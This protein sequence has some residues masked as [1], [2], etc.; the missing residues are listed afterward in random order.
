MSSA[1]EYAIN[2]AGGLGKLAK[3]VD[4]SPQAVYGWTLRDIPEEKVKKVAEA[5]KVTSVWLNN[6]RFNHLYK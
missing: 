4:E 5:I 2:K 1:V 6:K 3:L